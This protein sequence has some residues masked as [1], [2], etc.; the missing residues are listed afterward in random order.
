MRRSD[1]STEVAALVARA[2]GGDT[3]AMSHLYDR[4][5][6]DMY[7]FAL[8]IVRSADTAEDVVSETFFRAWTHLP[9]FKGGNFR[10]YLY[11]I[12]RHYA[13]DILKK[14]A[15]CVE[16]K[17]Q[18]EALNAS[19]DVL[20]NALTKERRTQI[21]EAL[22]LLCDCDRDVLVLRFFEELTVK[23]TAQ[24]LKRSEIWVRVNQYRALK[25]LEKLL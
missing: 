25:K 14:D 2:Q 15:R 11:T 21:A 13:Y 12:A 16:L 23:E 8:T 9:S 19:N 17:E 3:D 18:H 1:D 10:A 7:R 4:F 24:V 20:K 22:K 5:A 6:P